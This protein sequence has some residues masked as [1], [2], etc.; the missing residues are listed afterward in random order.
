MLARKS[1]FLM[2]SQFHHK[3]LALTPIESRPRLR[4]TK[5]YYTLI[6]AHVNRE[7][8]QRREKNKNEHG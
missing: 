8:F 4:T 7:E 3:H 1:Y 2:M 5:T 6:H